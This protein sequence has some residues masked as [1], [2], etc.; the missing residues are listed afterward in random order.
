M[1]IEGEFDPISFFLF[2]QLHTPELFCLE[3]LSRA[4]CRAE[5]G[6]LMKMSRI[7]ESD[8]GIAF[9]VIR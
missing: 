4:K 5:G 8:C 9:E 1:S 2:H 7:I 3:H 6:E